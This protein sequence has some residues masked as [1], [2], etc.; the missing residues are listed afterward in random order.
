[1]YACLLVLASSPVAA[2]AS[3]S[4]VVTVHIIEAGDLQ[5]IITSGDEKSEVI[6][7]KE[8][9]SRTSLTLREEAC[10]RIF[11]RLYQEGYTLKGTYGGEY[12]YHIESTLV[13]D[14]G[15]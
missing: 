15:Q 10:Q 4:E 11:A 9:E 3:G 1:L 5:I 13:L 6:V 8:K 12:N 2:Q 7:L 14:K